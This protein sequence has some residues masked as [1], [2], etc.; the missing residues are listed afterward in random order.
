MD[1][2]SFKR[3]FQIAPILLVD[4]IAAQR[5]GGQMSILALTEGSEDANY[6]DD[7]AYFAHFKPL[8]GATLIDYSPAEYPY[9]SQAMAA[10]AMIKNALRFS[11]HMDC[12]ARNNGHNYNDLQQTMTFLQ[13]QL[14]LHNQQ[15]G[16]FTVSTPAYVYTGC[17]L[18]ALRDVTSTGDKKVQGAFQWDFVQPLVTAQAAEQVFNNLYAKLT[19]GLPTPNPPTNS[20]ISTT[21]GNA[22][23]N[24]PPS[25]TNPSTIGTN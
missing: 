7:N 9:A 2:Q 10:N 19:G 17:L 25:P 20:G 3:S 1:I 13:Q 18:V 21:I 11:L 14:D 24:Q 23:T 5:S 22:P 6:A 4:G 12:P 15:G 16:S 8:S